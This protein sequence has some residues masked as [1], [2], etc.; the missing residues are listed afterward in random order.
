MRHL[1]DCPFS[2]SSKTVI[3]EVGGGSEVEVKVG[4]EDHRDFKAQLVTQQL[5]RDLLQ[6]GS[7]SK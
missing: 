2:H 5:S 7:V 4:A 3:Q 1:D 6:T